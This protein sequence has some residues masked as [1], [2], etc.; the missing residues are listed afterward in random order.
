[1][2]SEF[3]IFS[4]KI[5]SFVINYLFNC[6]IRLYLDILKKYCKIISTFFQET[7]VPFIRV[8][9][10]KFLKIL[11]N[12]CVY[13]HRN[14]RK[15]S[16]KNLFSELSIHSSYS[17]YKFNKSNR[18][19]NIVTENFTLCVRTFSKP[20][21]QQIFV[22]LLYLAQTNIFSRWIIFNSISRPTLYLL[23]RRTA[24]QMSRNILCI[25]LLR[26]S[27]NGGRG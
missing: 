4:S 18:S 2:N 14:F 8:S 20:E 3:W 16:L 13:I 21:L 17:L 10:G 7:R 22:I 26:D 6:L 1:M 27:R 19:V 24:G 15:A 23:K 25:R 9:L 11:S 5:R 12:S